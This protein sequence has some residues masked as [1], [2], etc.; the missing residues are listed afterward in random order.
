MLVEC[1]DVVVN[2][3]PKTDV[4]FNDIVDLLLEDLVEIGAELIEF[5]EIIQLRANLAMC[6][7]DINRGCN[8]WYVS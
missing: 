7:S 5:D 8:Y 1:R 3:F 6:R 2:L 4:I